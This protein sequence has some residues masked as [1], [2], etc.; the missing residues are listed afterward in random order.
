MAGVRKISSEC[1]AVAR[2]IL[3]GQASVKTARAE[4]W[5]EE[6]RAALSSYNEWVEANGLPLHEYRRF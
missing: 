2:N 4:S 5:L 6:N 1:E 3:L